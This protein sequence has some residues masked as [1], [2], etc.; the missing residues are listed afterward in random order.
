MGG[1]WAG[2][3]NDCWDY[4]YGKE[5]HVVSQLDSIVRA[6]NFDGVDIDYEYFYESA[7]AQNFLSS[8]TTGLKNTLPV[9][10]IITHAPMEPDSKIGTAY[11]NILKANAAILDFLMPQYYNGLTRPALDGFAS[12]GL[13]SERA[14]DHYDNLVTDMFSGDQ[15]KVVFGF[16]IDDCNSSSGSGGGSSNSNADK[17]Q[18]SNVVNEIE[19]TY[20]CNHG[21]AFFWVADD[22]QNGEWSSAVSNALECDP[23][24]TKS[25]SNI[26][27]PKC[28]T[29]DSTIAPTSAPS[30]GK[31]GK[32]KGG[33]GKGGKG[34]GGKGKG[35]KGKG[36]KGKDTNSPSNSSAPSKGKGGKGKG[37][38]NRRKLK[39]EKPKK[40]SKSP[41]SSPISSE[42]T[43]ALHY[44][45][46][47][48]ACDGIILDSDWC[49]ASPHRCEVD[50]N[51]LSCYTTS[52]PTAVPVTP[53]TPAPTDC[54]EETFTPTTSPTSVMC[55]CSTCTLAILHSIACL[56]GECHS[57]AARMNWKQ[58]V[59]GGS[60]SEADACM[61]VADEIP[62]VCGA[63][64]CTTAH[65]PSH[66]PTVT[67]TRLPTHIP[68]TTSPTR[69]P[70]SD[71]TRAP[72]TY[73][74]T[75]DPTANPTTHSPTKVP[76]RNP[77]S[78]DPTTFPTISPTVNPTNEPTR[79]PISFNPTID[80]TVDPT[81]N[82]SPKPTS[83]P[84]MNPVLAEDNDPT[85]DPTL[86][87]IHQPTISPL[88][89]PTPQ[90]IIDPRNN[91]GPILGEIAQYGV[92]FNH[93]NCSASLNTLNNPGGNDM[94]CV[95]EILPKGNPYSTVLYDYE[96]CESPHPDV[97]GMTS[98]SK[99]AN[100]EILAIIDLVRDEV[101]VLANDSGSG[102]IKFCI[103]TDVNE[104]IEGDIESVNFV[105]AFITVNINLDG[106]FDIQPVVIEENTDLSEKV[107][108]AFE[109]YYSVYAHQCDP[110]S[111]LNTNKV[112]SQ[113]EILGVC[114]MSAFFD[115]WI[116]KVNTLTLYQ[117]NPN[118]GAD[119]TSAP[120]TN[121]VPNII[122][123][124]DCSLEDQRKCLIQTT[125]LSKFFINQ[126]EVVNVAGEVELLIRVGADFNRKR[127]LSLSDGQGLK[128]NK[129]RLADKNGFTPK[130]DV[131]IGV[132]D[133]NFRTFNDRFSSGGNNSFYSSKLLSLT[134]GSI[135]CYM[136]N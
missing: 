56:E 118:G 9:G 2:D 108:D 71:P 132:A 126:G 134:V 58:T 135:L 42:P 10:S 88:D 31:G 86:F 110:V 30:K 92:E 3:V 81:K 5:N 19:D 38:G 131:Q 133:L 48:G 7:E 70:T 59:V 49:H 96:D 26:G 47:N 4:C 73:P 43:G 91:T 99:D 106:N 1:S 18:A 16:C 54:Y 95:F 35:G 6:Q 14:I 100:G 105:K 44:C 8:I 104:D 12:L 64:R 28:V 111:H 87:P 45:A 51:S 97:V 27:I 77:T 125:L 50:C 116:E 53:A 98:T 24:P 76:T 103:R 37:K 69:S 32:G 62:S 75:V 120:V 41:T 68:T 124:Y 57:C 22:D 94:N 85:F 121:G 15:S 101:G 13:G 130:F 34:K 63:C 21:G 39:A 115:T 60:K 17:D 89:S 80:P 25:P 61:F 127:T 90:I 72:V 78:Y 79:T 84:T 23:Q 107:L 128:S 67:P 33:K 114:V 65:P 11:Y 82:P 46:F 102:Q 29:D 113:G 119:T 36:G 93:C 117:T 112:I 20:G 66:V 129:R 55:G 83:V 123:N 52:H 74:T 136:F 122:S 40:S 109:K